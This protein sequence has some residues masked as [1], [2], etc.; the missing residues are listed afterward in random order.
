MKPIEKQVN[1]NHCK[2]LT[3][4]ID[5]QSRFLCTN[6]QCLHYDW[7][8]YNFIAP[9]EQG[10]REQRAR[11]HGAREQGAKEQGAR[12][13]GASEQGAREQGAREQWIYFHIRKILE[14]PRNKLTLPMQVCLYEIA[15]GKIEN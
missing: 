3:V 8:Q 2:Y 11:E 15:A 4:C 9:Y 7:H 13:Q 14:K 5:T 10:A 1:I 6:A 12:E